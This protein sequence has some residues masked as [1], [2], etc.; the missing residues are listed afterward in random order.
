MR[1][2]EFITA[3]GGAAVT[4]PLTAHLRGLWPIPIKQHCPLTDVQRQRVSKL[5]KLTWHERRVLEARVLAD[6]PMT[7]EELG[8]EFGV[9]RARVRQLEAHVLE[10]MGRINPGQIRGI[11]RPEVV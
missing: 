3:I 6:K 4:W 1:R 5:D 9:C 10:K 11:D 7:L 2:R 8:A